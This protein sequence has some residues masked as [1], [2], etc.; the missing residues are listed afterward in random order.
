MPFVPVL[1]T[2]PGGRVPDSLRTGAGEPEV[3]MVKALYFPGS[4]RRLAELVMMAPPYRL[5]SSI[6]HQKVGVAVVRT[7]LT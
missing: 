2:R 6:D 3:V 4:M 5:N 1:K 7:T